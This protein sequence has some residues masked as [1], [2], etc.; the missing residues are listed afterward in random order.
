MRSAN[1]GNGN[2]VA[3]VN[4]SGN[5]NNNNAIN[6]NRAAPD[7]AAIRAGR[8]HAVQQTR[9]TGTRSA[10]PAGMTREQG[11]GDGVIPRDGTP[12]SAPGTE[13]GIGVEDVIGY[14]ALWDS[15]MKCRRGV[16]WKSSAASF[17]LDGAEQ[18]DKLCRELH[19]G[20]YK[21][22]PVSH[23]TV[24]SPKRREIVGIAF[25]DRVY[26]RSLN[27]NCVYPIMSRSWIYDNY[28][29][30]EGK[31]TDF[32]RGRMKCFMERYY[33]RRGPQG[34]VLSIDIRGY[35]PNM[36]HDVAEACFREE[37]PP[38]AFEMV[39]GVLRS[40]YPGDVG[41]NPGSQIVQIAGVSL[42][43]RLDHFAKEVL[44]VK[45]YGRYMD[46]I[47]IIH[48]DRDYLEFCRDLIGDE[49]SDL[50][51]ELHPKKTAITP[52]SQKNAFLGFDFRLTGTGKVVM[53]VSPESVKRM[54]RKVARLWVLESMGA[55]PP[56]TTEEA[57]GGWRAHAAK[58]DSR[59]LLERCDKWFYDVRRQS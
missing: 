27:D 53:T 33:R 50:G 40:Q 35:Y 38:W 20:T 58:G 32:A 59:L 11:G 7:R 42:L 24:T 34:W 6:G 55:R 48:H 21:P 28:A 54:R 57:Y 16:M 31:G 15:M 45:L 5:C 30:Q 41:Y 49:V 18:V 17:V 26:Q 37:L 39:K 1:R 2:N 43:S 10:H 8:Q 56:G 19:D 22:R 12:A 52:L 4:S 51:F 44:R 13:C 23:F 36:R 3:I 14:D 47:R 25:R 46:D 29:C 9:D